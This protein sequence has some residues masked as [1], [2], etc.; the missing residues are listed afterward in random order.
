MREKATD[1]AIE[2]AVDI[3]CRALHNPK[4][5]NGDKSDSGFFGMALSSSNSQNDRNGIDM[6]E[7]VG[8]FK[9]ELTAEL[10]RLRD[11]EDYFPSWLDSDYGPCK[12][13]GEIADKVGIPHSQFSY[14]SSVSI[15]DDYVS[16][17]FGYGAPRIYH[18]PLPGGKWLVTDL[19]GHSDLEKV[20]QHVLDGN[21]IGFTLE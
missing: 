4:F 8:K 14:K 16:C 11:S 9:V 3:W 1:K 15:H 6:S 2:R 17:S 12:I 10:K 20:K 19:C 21:S 7:L 5:D 18:Y 13:L